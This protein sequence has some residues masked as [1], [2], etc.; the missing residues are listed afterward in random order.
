MA[1]VYAVITEYLQSGAE[2]SLEIFISDEHARAY[3]LCSIERG[4]TQSERHDEQPIW[5]QG[6]LDACAKARGADGDISNTD[7]QFAVEC[8]NNHPTPF[9]MYWIFGRKVNT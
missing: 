7:F 1:K 4:V 3:V 9:E 2:P 8:F 6:V 5:K